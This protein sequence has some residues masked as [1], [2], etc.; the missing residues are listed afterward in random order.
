M[1]THPMTRHEERDKAPV[2]SV[3]GRRDLNLSTYVLTLTKEN[4][5]FVPGQHVH[6]GVTGSSDLREYSIYSGKDDTTIEV[7]IR[8][9]G[10]GLVSR[11]LRRLGRHDAVRLEGPFGYFTI[12]DE[13]R[14]DRFLFV[15]TGTGIA[16]FRSI[17]TSYT[18]IEYRL[19]HGIGTA[20]DR[21][22]YHYFDPSR[23]TTCLSKQLPEDA[24]RPYGNDD[25]AN[26]QQWFA[27][28]VT[29]YLSEHPIDPATKC[30]LCGNCD[31]IY[32][33]FDILKRFGVPSSN[34]Y[35]EVYF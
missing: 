7:L 14:S 4:L 13:A 9:I 28:R 29:N 12:P 16:P 23:I 10:D 17:A 3:V 5:E 1:L 6:L 22:D 27:G 35:S 26:E 11:Q 34:L 31:M 33:V 25:H 30:Y 21:F 8:E 32:E 2:H 24:V 18:G 19:I 15:A 20:E